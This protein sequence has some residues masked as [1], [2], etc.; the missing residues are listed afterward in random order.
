MCSEQIVI[1]VKPSIQRRQSYMTPN[2]KSTTQRDKQMA[3][4]GHALPYSQENQIK[5]STP[6]KSRY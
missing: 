6:P 5:P 2:L 3:L 1:T 4:Y